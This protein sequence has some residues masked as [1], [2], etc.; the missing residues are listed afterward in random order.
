MKYP[1]GTTKEEEINEIKKNWN[2]ESLTSSELSG[3]QKN[4][5]NDIRKE[6]PG[7]YFYCDE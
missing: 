4:A 5:V 6:K 2:P 7:R 1:L 3:E